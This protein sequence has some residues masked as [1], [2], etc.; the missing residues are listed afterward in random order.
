MEG[1]VEEVKEEKEERSVWKRREGKAGGGKEGKWGEV[2]KDGGEKRSLPNQLHF[3]TFL[4]CVL[5]ARQSIK[6]NKTLLK[7]NIQPMPHKRNLTIP[8]PKLQLQINCKTLVLM[9]LQL[10]STAL[11]VRITTALLQSRKL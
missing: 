3:M 1:R 5:C 6:Y 8:S 11:D 4:V 7:C 2:E 10:S 9:P